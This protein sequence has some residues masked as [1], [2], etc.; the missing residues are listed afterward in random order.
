MSNSLTK[1]FYFHFKW[2]LL[3]G[4]VL[5]LLFSSAGTILAAPFSDDPA[6]IVVF[7]SYDTIHGGESG[8]QSYGSFSGSTC[9]VTIPTN[10]GTL[11]IKTTT[12]TSKSYFEVFSDIPYN[13]GLVMEASLNHMGKNGT[14]LRYCAYRPWVSDLG[15]YQHVSTVFG[16]GISLLSTDKAT[17]FSIFLQAKANYYFVQGFFAYGDVMYDFMYNSANLE[18]GAGFNY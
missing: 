4:I 14:A 16:P 13:E 8:E 6:R 9:G 18:F 3:S 2:V 7:F 12:D 15:D 10:F 17:T 5:I 1:G 11:G